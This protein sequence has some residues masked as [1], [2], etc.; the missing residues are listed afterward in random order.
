M[1]TLVLQELHGPAAEDFQ[2][3]RDAHPGPALLLQIRTGG[4]PCGAHVPASQ[5]HLLRA[6]AHYRHPARE[7][8]SVWYS[9]FGV[10]ITVIGLFSGWLLEDP[11]GA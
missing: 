11:R 9:S 8:A 2:G 5:E 7:D 1:T 3:C 10:V 4:R 6:A